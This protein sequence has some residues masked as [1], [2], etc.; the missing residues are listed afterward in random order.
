MPS[1]LAIHCVLMAMLL[2]PGGAM[3]AIHDDVR[4]A[5]QQVKGEIGKE[6]QADRATAESVATYQIQEALKKDAIDL[7][8]T[9]R[10]KDNACME[11]MVADQLSAASENTQGYLVSREKQQAQ[12]RDDPRRDTRAY[13]L[14][15]HAR[16]VERY[17]SSMDVARG[18]CQATSVAFP[19][20][21]ILATTLLT[22]YGSGEG[23]SEGYVSGQREAAEDFTERLVGLNFQS[24]AMQ[25]SCNT[26]QCKAFEETRKR[27]QSVESSSRVSYNSMIARR[28]SPSDLSQ[29]MGAGSSVNKGLAGSFAP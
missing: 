5:F 11:S 29:A 9:M 1:S 15:R 4:K 19:G 24:R 3:A 18:A 6:T 22:S 21:D 23:S 17:C 27:L 2:A 7:S 14:E 26:E 28:T 16:S 20:G 13:L 10:R 25:V 8:E 12:R